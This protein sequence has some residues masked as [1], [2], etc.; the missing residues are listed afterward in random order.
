MRKTYTATYLYIIKMV[1][2]SAT[3]IAA[4]LIANFA[5][6]FLNKIVPDWFPWVVNIIFILIGL[7]FLFMQLT[8]KKPTFM[9]DEEG[10]KYKRKTIKYND[11]KRLIPAQGGSEP[12]V[13]FKD[14]QTYVLELSWFLAK[15]RKEILAIIAQ[16]I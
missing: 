3:V 8:A 12:E 14:N 2:L 9:F 6:M 7:L 1:M 5:M 15:D 13:V 10:F 4:F 16:N 11:I